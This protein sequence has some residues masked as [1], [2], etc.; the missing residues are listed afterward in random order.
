MNGEILAAALGVAREL[1]RGNEQ[2]DD[3]AFARQRL[4]RRFALESVEQR[5][6]A[7]VHRVEAAR[8]D[9]LEELL[10]AA[11]VVVDGRQVHRGGRGD[12]PQARRLEPVLHEQ[13][14]RRVEDLVFGHRGPARLRKRN[15]TADHWRRSIHC[16]AV[17]ASWP[18]RRGPQGS[19]QRA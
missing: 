9:R 4:G 7:L 13:G 6:S 11:E 5:D 8:E 17:P 10:L 14:F 3:D 16:P 2:R 15:H 18:A 12:R 1:E 19:R